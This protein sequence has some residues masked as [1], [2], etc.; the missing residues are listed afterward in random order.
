MSEQWLSGLRTGEGGGRVVLMEGA[1]ASEKELGTHRVEVVLDETTVPESD[2]W[3]RRFAPPLPRS[4]A[5][6]LLLE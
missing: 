3:R 5:V 2:R 1:M 4:E 6:R